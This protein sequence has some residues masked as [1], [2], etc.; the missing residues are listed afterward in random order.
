MRQLTTVNS[1]N[2]KLLDMYLDIL[3]PP[4]AHGDCSGFIEQHNV[5]V[6]GSLDRFAADFSIECPDAT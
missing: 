4:A 6:A 2:K 1:S 3:I 5:D